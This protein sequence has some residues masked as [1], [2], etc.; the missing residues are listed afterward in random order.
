VANQPEV[1]AHAAA[2]AAAVRAAGPDAVV[3]VVGHSNTV[4]KIVEALGGPPRPDLCDTQY[5]TM[6]IVRLDGPGI[7]ARVARTSYGAPDLA[8]AGTCAAMR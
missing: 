2:V 3:L 8:D 5:A 4:P 1:A 6:T 7:P